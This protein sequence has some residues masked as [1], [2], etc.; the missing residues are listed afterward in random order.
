VPAAPVPTVAAGTLWARVSAASV[1]QELTACGYVGTSLDMFAQSLTMAN[2]RSLCYNHP[3]CC[4]G[5]YARMTM[6]LLAVAVRGAFD[7]HGERCTRLSDVPFIPCVPFVVAVIS[8]PSPSSWRLPIPRLACCLGR[9]H[10][11][12]CCASCANEP[13]GSPLPPCRTLPRDCVVP[14]RH[15][16]SN[17]RLQHRHWTRSLWL[18]FYPSHSSRDF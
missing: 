3:L 7:H 9:G 6:C 18:A 10:G 1:R 12:C 17:A 8:T 16:H 13:R 11:R 15:H 14:L 5:G 4:A 2:S